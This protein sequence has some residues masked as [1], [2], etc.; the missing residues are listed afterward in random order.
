MDLTHYL[1]YLALL[2]HEFTAKRVLY[3]SSN[4]LNGSHK[5]LTVFSTPVS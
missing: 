5:L 3:S 2:F 4:C 1:L